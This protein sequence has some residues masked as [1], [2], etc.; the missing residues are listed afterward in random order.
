MKRVLI[1]LSM[2]GVLL[3]LLPA[4]SIAAVWY[5]DGGISVP[6]DGASWMQAKDH[7]KAAID[8]ADNGDEIW[9]KKGIYTLVDEI[10]VYK[11]VEIYGGVDGSESRREERDWV[12]NIT[13]V[14]GD[15]SVR[16]FYVDD[17]NN[18]RTIRIG[19]T[20]DGFSITN[21]AGAGI[22]SVATYA[23]PT[24]QNCSIYYNDGP[25]IFNVYSS[26]VINNCTI[27]GNNSSDPYG[28]GGILNRNIS[29]SIIT[30]CTIANNW[31]GGIGNYH[32][33]PIVSESIIWGNTP[34]QVVPGA[35]VTF[36]DIQYG[37]GGEGNIDADPLFVNP[38]EGDFSL[39][40]NSPAL[41]IGAYIFSNYTP[42]NCDVLSITDIDED[43]VIDELDQCPE[44]PRGAAVYSN[45]CEAVDLY[46][47]EELNQAILDQNVTINNLN[48][49]IIEKDATITQLKETINS[50]SVAAASIGMA[51][52][53]LKSADEAT[54]TTV[55][56]IVQTAI[57]QAKAEGVNG[58]FIEKA[59][60]DMEKGQKEFDKMKYDKAIEHYQRAW[61]DI[62]KA[63][64]S[65]DKNRPNDDDDD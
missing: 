33:K 44:T 54:T 13:I 6:G 34:S 58:K 1:V 39:Q 53:D 36:S 16:C 61:K 51:L 20:I 3:C 25:G 59:E 50:Q 30:N 56:Q 65:G 37:Y 62:Q 22:F 12:G 52:L 57:E 28:G 8:A 48:K 27:W 64:E 45:G 43:G 40:P 10:I 21:G 29:H 19:A 26:S 49:Q 32:S 2:L 11:N 41:D 9:V 24:F 4:T 60:K 17:D 18:N 42:I 7:I 15:N 23:I 46:T 31:G 5:V 14:D 55:I 63:V 38:E 35:V 47:Q